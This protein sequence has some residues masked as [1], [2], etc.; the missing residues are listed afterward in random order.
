MSVYFKAR[1]PGKVHMHIQRIP[2]SEIPRHDEEQFKLWIDEKWR[3]KD[4]LLEHFYRE[5]AFPD[6]TAARTVSGMYEGSNGVENQQEQVQTLSRSSSS[7]SGMGNNSITGGFGGKYRKYS[8][9]SEKA[10]LSGMTDKNTQQSNK[11]SEEANAFSAENNHNIDISSETTL[12]LS[13]LKQMSRPVTE[14]MVIKTRLHNFLVLIW[15]ASFGILLTAALLGLYWLV[16]VK[17][18]Q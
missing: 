6:V 4:E 12:D 8:M 11:I 1:P 10:Q 3:I 16:N 13:K 9:I 15:T 5:G 7:S 2:L 17:T 18:S 14:T